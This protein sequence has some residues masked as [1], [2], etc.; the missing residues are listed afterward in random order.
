MIKNVI[1]DVG[2]VLVDFRW[3]ALMADLGLPCERQD[4]FE[5]LVFGSK[6]WGELDRGV[7]DEEYVVNKIRENV[8][9]H[10][11][12]F[13][14]VWA[15]QVDLVE[16]Y[17]YV[18]KWLDSL[19]EKGLKIYLLSNYPKSIFALHEERGKFTFIDKIDG[20]VVSGFEGMVKPDAE[21]Y[22]LLMDRYGLKAEECVFIDDRPENIEA[23]KALGMEGI[24]FESYEQASEELEKI[25]DL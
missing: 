11:D 5:K 20:R 2:G 25:A 1:F 13:E 17:D 10:I 8:G 15:N 16:T 9:D 12:A 14:L 18:N 6:W 19:K 23:A 24:V 3:R 7:L 4:E 22:K 21:I